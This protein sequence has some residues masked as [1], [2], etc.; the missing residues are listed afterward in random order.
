MIVCL[1]QNEMVVLSDLVRFRFFNTDI[2]RTQKESP[3]TAI[4]VSFILLLTYPKVLEDTGY[5]SFR[6]GLLK[7]RVVDLLIL[8]RIA[9]MPNK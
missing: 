9:D 6:H 8:R 2:R 5:N 1:F 3:D 4:L 7:L